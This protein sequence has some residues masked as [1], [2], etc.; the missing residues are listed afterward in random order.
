MYHKLMTLHERDDASSND[1]SR[2]MIYGLVTRHRMMR[3]ICTGTMGVIYDIPVC[4]IYY[5]L[6]LWVLSMIF[7]FVISFA[8]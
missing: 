5:V 3:A 4:D 7:L 6:A 8:D 2:E 1:K